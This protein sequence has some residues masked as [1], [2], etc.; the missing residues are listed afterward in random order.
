MDAIS[1][2]LR[3]LETSAAQF[4]RSAAET[5][6]AT[7]PQTPGQAASSAGPA[8]PPGDLAQGLV[9]QMMALVNY[10]ANIRAIDAS[11]QMFKRTLDLIG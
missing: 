6:R 8:Q 4:T 5:V 3:G 10:R 7:T 11:Q 2:S 9:G 1:I